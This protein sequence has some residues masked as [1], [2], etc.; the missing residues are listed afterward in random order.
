[1]FG[2]TWHVV[3]EWA[4]ATNLVVISSARQQHISS[5]SKIELCPCKH[6]AVWLACI[7]AEWANTVVFSDKEVLDCRLC[8]RPGVDEPIGRTCAIGVALLLEY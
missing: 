2:L 7:T 5:V 6:E 3:F 1:M 8:M 4:Q